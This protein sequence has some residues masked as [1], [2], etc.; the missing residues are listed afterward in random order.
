MELFGKKKSRF[1]SLMNQ[2][3]LSYTA[4]LCM[5]IEVILSDTEFKGIPIVV[6]S[7]CMD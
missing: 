1:R 5:S 3:T 7:K 2:A 4:L 6:N